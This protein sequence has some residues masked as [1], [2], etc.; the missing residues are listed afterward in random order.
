MIKYRWEAQEYAK[1]SSAQQGWARELIAKLDLQGNEHILD[2]GCGDGKVTAKIAAHVPNGSVVGVDN[3][4]S[5]IE[6]AQT[7]YPV[8]EYPNLSF[9]LEDARELSFDQRFDI[10]FSNA[11]LHWVRNHRPVLESIWRSLRPGG[12][13]LLQMGGSANAAS[14][15][16]VLDRMKE[17]GVWKPYF[18]GFAFPY[19][20]HGPNEY[21]I[22]L[23]QSGLQPVRVELIQKDMTHEGQT[24]LAGW[25]RTTWLPYTERIPEQKREMFIGEIVERYLRKYPPDSEGNTHVRM[26]RLEV[27]AIKNA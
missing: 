18:E 7:E 2:V 3:S 10:V 1:H 26:V 22:W 27:E 5:M 4:P 6:L 14:I 15:L 20:F 25:I 24:G 12:R 13:T 8:A 21:E 17:D 19:G 23:K 9:Q 16:S 11:A